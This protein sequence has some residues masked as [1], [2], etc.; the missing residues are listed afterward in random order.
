MLFCDFLFRPRQLPTW[1][2]R[3]IDNHPVIPNL[4]AVAGLL[5]I[6]FT[7][8][9]FMGRT[10]PHQE[11]RAVV[12]IV[13]TASEPEFLM[14][15][16]SRLKEICRNWFPEEVRSIVFGLYH[17]PALYLVIPFLLFLELLF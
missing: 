16:I 12:Q 13:Q 15:Q 6:T 9:H 17:N 11:G 14:T 4:I 8:A 1:W 2:V 3:F 7:L 10:P 5:W